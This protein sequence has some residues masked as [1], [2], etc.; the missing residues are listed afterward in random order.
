MS[1]DRVD[2]VR[3]IDQGFLRPRIQPGKALPEERDIQLTLLEIAS[4]QIRDLELPPRGGLQL[5]RI[6]YD[7]IIIEV[8]SRHRVIGFRELRLLL[9]GDGLPL[10]IKG[11]DAEALRIIHIVTED[12]RP[13]LLR[14]GLSQNLPEAVARENIVPENHRDGIPADKVRPDQEGL[15]EPVRRGLYSIAQTDAK[16]RSVTEKLLKAGRIHRRGDQEDIPDAGVHKNGERIIDHRLVIDRKQL[17]G[18]HPRERVK[19]RAGASGQYNSLHDFPQ[20][21]SADPLPRQKRPRPGE[22]RRSLGIYIIL[23]ILA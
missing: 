3:G 18:C 13:S 19:S 22:G 14:G 9:N 11:N 16:L 8:E 2:E 5:P 23:E 6:I 4:V 1:L 15:G 7:P 20:K 21:S 10:F 12:R 17:L